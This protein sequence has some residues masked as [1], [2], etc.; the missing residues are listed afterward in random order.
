MVEKSV[1]M[2]L[3]ICR[4]QETTRCD[5]SQ[6]TI[7]YY[8]SASPRG[9]ARA[10]ALLEAKGLVRRVRRYADGSPA[11]S[12]GGKLGRSLGSTSY[13]LTLPFGTAPVA[14]GTAP[15]AVGVLPQWQDPTATMADKL[16]RELPTELR[17]ELPTKRSRSRQAAPS[18]DVARVFE[19]WKEILAPLKYQRPVELTG[20]RRKKI[21]EALKSYTADDLLLAIKGAR[22]SAWHC[23]ENDRG[24]KYIDL[25]TIFKADAID[26]HIARASQTSVPRNANGALLQ[27]PAAPD[28]YNW[29]GEA[30]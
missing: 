13:E 24:E 16:L 3:I 4:N 29:K 2:A 21:D 9:A 18:P 6:A 8:A 10:L 14:V 5:P 27:Q 12:H 11:P 19:A 25:K 22:K 23:G 26:G 30:K 17:R 15:V 20:P 1:L 28:E 7:A